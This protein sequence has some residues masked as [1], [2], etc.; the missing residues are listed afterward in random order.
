MFHHGWIKITGHVLDS[1]IRKLESTK[2][3]GGVS[4]GSITLHN[5]IV[6]FRAP[7]GE[8]T[9]LEVEQH[10]ETV[11]LAAGNEAPLL[12]SPD[13]TKAIFDAKDPRINVIEVGKA[14]KAADEGRFRKQLE[15]KPKG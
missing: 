14:F 4:H 13:G 7:N 9:K 11:D 10:I 8:M 15:D 2:V 12:V 5:Y 1:R 6:E 3:G